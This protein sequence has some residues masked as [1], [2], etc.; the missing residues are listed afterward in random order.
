MTKVLPLRPGRSTALLGAVLVAIAAGANAAVEAADAGG[1]RAGIENAQ[2]I[3]SVGGAVTEILYA[4]GAESRIV[5]VD[6][7]SLYPPRA[8]REK[9]NV[10]YMRQLSAEGVLGL[11]PSL[12]LAAEDA[13]PRETIALIKS[14]GVPVVR[15]PERHTGEGIVE[16]VRLVA[17]V[18]GEEAAGACLANSVLRDLAALADIR[19]RLA[20][21][22]RV[23][24]LLSFANGR[25]MV[26]GRGTAADGIIRLAG[27]IN[28]VSAYE[29]YKILA[30]EAVLSA[31]PDVVLAMDREG[32]A[33]DA[34]AVFAHPAFKLTA[35]A[36]RGRFISM[37]GLYLLGFGPRTA[38][39]ARDFA[40]QAYPTLAIPALPSEAAGSVPCR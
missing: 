23:L 25:P 14:A 29:G 8:L 10:G 36:K 40:R 35:A 20:E 39:A 1:R 31:R 12:V 38:R 9:P 21:P 13:G 24:F 2:R 32:M 6:T 5:A 4:L 33:L 18:V 22:V 27:A 19:A 16:K 34:T 28:A 17:R 37:D 30:D 11:A 15:V 7:T 3:V 26:A